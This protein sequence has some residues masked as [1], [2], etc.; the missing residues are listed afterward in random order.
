MACAALIWI[1]NAMAQPAHW[2]TSRGAWHPS[3]QAGRQ[4]TPRCYPL[5][6]PGNGAPCRS[7]ARPTMPACAG[8]HLR[9]EWK[10]V[11]WSC[12]RY[13]ATVC[14]AG[15]PMHNLDVPMSLHVIT[16]SLAGAWW[17]AWV[18]GCLPPTLLAGWLVSCHKV[19]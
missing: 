13:L 4:W 17:L 16:C 8:L 5:G 12:G 11:H 2:P 7:D 3:P 9:V 10:A 6:R 1:R 14:S 19:H 15:A 18:S